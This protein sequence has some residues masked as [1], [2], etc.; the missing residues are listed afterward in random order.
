VISIALHVFKQAFCGWSF[1]SDCWL[2][3]CGV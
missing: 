3:C 2:A 1:R